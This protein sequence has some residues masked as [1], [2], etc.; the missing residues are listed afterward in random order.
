M[1]A[2]GIGDIKEFMISNPDL[3][4]RDV[5]IKAMLD[6]KVQEFS[7]IIISNQDYNFGSFFDYLGIDVG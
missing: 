1:K 2:F 3:Y 5:Y 7:P 4:G 6:N